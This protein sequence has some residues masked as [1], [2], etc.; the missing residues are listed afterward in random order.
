MRATVSKYDH[1]QRRINY[2]EVAGTNNTSDTHIAESAITYT[3]E[4]FDRLTRIRYAKTE[5]VTGLNYK[6]NDY[7]WLTKIE[8]VWSDENTITLRSYTYDKHGKGN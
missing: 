4:N 1:F 5:G 7:N 8:E 3:Y 6:Y 2:A